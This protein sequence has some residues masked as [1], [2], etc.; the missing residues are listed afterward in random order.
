MIIM[1]IMMMQW[2]DAHSWNGTTTTQP[3]IPTCQ[4]LII[5]IIISVWESGFFAPTT[6]HFQN[7]TDDKRRSQRIPG[8]FPK[9][10]TSIV[11][12][13]AKFIHYFATTRRDE[14]NWNLWGNLFFRRTNWLAVP[15]IIHSSTSSD[16]LLAGWLVW[17]KLMMVERCSRAR[18]LAMGD[19]TH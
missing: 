12:T 17:G 13:R 8:W 10:L 7:R 19:D 15:P 5:I 9:L 18:Q 6:T 11:F 3:L 14:E 1:M 2:R 16:F 4:N